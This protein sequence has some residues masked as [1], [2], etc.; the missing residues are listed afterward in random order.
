MPRDLS[1]LAEEYLGLDDVPRVVNT[2][3]LD[4]RPGR[5]DTFWV[6][7]ERPA[8]HVEV[9]AVLRIV[10]QHAYWYVQQGV[11]VSDAALRHSAD[12]FDARI[13]PEVRRI[14]GSEPFPGIDNDPRMT[15][16]SGEVPGVAGY[17]SS[18]DS[19]PRSV[20]PYSNEREMVYLNT[21]VLEPGSPEYLATLTHE[22]TH[23]V[24]AGVHPSED[25]WIKEGLAELVAGL[26]FP[27]QRPSAR[28]MLALP[29]LQLTAWSGAG[30]EDLR[31]AA[32]YEATAWFLRYVVD[33]FGQEPLDTLLMRDTLGPDSISAFL[34][35]QR[36][37]LT[38]ADLFGDWV[39]ANL[40]GGQGARGIVPYATAPVGT[41]AIRRLAPPTAVDETVA[42][43]GADYYEVPWS[44]G[45]VVEFAGTTTAPLISARPFSGDAMWYGGR[46]DTTVSTM[47]RIFDLT[48]ADGA[49]L[50]YAVWHDLE[51]DYDYAYVSASRDGRTWTLL[52]TPAM[53]RA[54]PNGNNLGVGYT[55]MSGGG[56]TPDW[57]EE[58]VDLG[59][60]AG[61]PVWIRFSSIADDALARQGVAIDDI[62]I[63]STGFVDGAEETDGGWTLRGW[64]PVGE[65]IPQSWSVQVVAYS[66][67]GAEVTRIPVDGSGRGRWISP[68]GPLDRVVVI[69]SGTA[70]VTLQRGRYALRVGMG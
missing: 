37:S 12:V 4:Y 9:D 49:A 58:Q 6:T 1:Q 35:E 67:E 3:P 43:F 68:P 5:I 64:S 59:A 27:E 40:V 30:D 39:V 47:E 51:R 2:E 65:T 29:D 20:H 25:T 50:N 24:H 26:L 18:A 69:V 34:S 15:I 60:Y 13:Y 42:Q 31:L 33:R 36:S 57:V 52:D 22:L 63:D 32:H 54:N 55:G 17:A 44:P 11:P 10:G 21:G 8:D 62:R 19:Y 56:P 46:S 14:V 66:T 48:G 41:P 28:A 38:M 53:T 70:P 61:A 45:V 16:F 7:R 23:V